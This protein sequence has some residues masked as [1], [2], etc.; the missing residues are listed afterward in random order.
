MSN[1]RHKPYEIIT[2]LRQVEA[3]RGQE[4]PMTDRCAKLAFPS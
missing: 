4:M 1:K 3:L 2:K